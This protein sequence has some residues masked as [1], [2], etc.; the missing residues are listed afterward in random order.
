MKKLLLFA[1]LFPL[2]LFGQAWST[3]LDP[4]RAVDWSGAGFAIPNYTVPCATQPTMLA[5][6]SNA[7]ANTTSVVNS[8]NSCDT[9]HNVVNIPAGTYYLNMTQFPSHGFEVIRGAGAQSTT[10]IFQSTGGCVGGIGNQGFCMRDPGAIYNGNPA[11][12]PPSGSQQCSWTGGLTQGSTSIT[13][14]SCGGTPPNG[15]ILILDQADDTSDT[16][17]VYICQ[18][19]N[20]TNCNN[21]GT[22]NENGRVIS[23]TGHSQQQVTQITGVT[24]LGGGSYTV[25]ISPGVYFTNVRSGQSPG[26]WW[27]GF[28]QNEGVENMTLDGSA[29]T[30]GGTIGI[31]Q[32][33]QCWVSGII[34]LNAGRNHIGLYMSMSDVIQNSYFYGAQ[35]HGSSSYGNEFEETS[36]SL[37]QNNIYQQTVAPIMFGQGSGNVI[38]YNFD[39]YNEYTGNGSVPPDVLEASAASHNS[40]NE[41]NLWEGNIGQAIWQDNVWGSSAQN[42]FYRNAMSGWQKQFSGSAAVCGST[43]CESTAFILRPFNRALNFVGNVIGQ[44]SFNVAYE[45]YAT[46]T[47][48]GVNGSEDNSI[49]SLGWATGGFGGSS[50]GGCTATLC[51]SLVRS[52][53]MRWDNYD[54]VGKTVRQNTTEGCPASATYVTANCTNFGTPSTTLPASLYYASKPSWWPSTKAWPAVGPDVTTGNVSTC[55]GGTYASSRGTLSAQCTGGS[56][57]AASSTTAAWASHVVSNPAMDCYLKTLNGPPD[58]SGSVLAFNPVTCYAVTGNTYTATATNLVMHQGDPLPPLIFSMST[59]TGS[60]STVFN[61]QPTLSTT[62]TSSSTPGTYPITISAGTQSPVNPADSISYVGGTMTV[63]APDN[64]G[65]VLANSIAYPSGFF[66][67]PAFAAMN[68]TSNGVANMVGDGTTLNDRAFERL[69]FFSRWGADAKVNTVTSG[70]NCA[71]TWVSGTGFTGIA[72]AQPV[73]LAGVVRATVSV[74]SDTAMIVAGTCTTASNVDARLPW[75]TVSISGT[76]VTATAGPSFA[77]YT[78]NSITQMV[79]NGNTYTISTV[80]DSTHITLSTAPGNTSDADAYFGNLSSTSLNIGSRPL[81]LYFPSGTYLLSTQIIVPGS[82][83]NFFGTGPQSSILKLAPNSAQFQT[84]ATQFISPQSVNFNQNFREH[85]DSMGFEI[86]VGN[87]FAEALTWLGNNEGAVRNVQIWSDDSAALMGFNI[88]RSYSGPSMLEDIAIYG[89][90]TAFNTTQSEYSLPA[91][92]VTLEGQTVAG[93]DSIG[94]MKLQYR[95]LL[96]YEPPATYV[97]HPHASNSNVVL[98]DSEIIANG[99]PSVP[100]ILNS[101]SGSSIY[102]TNVSVSGYSTSLSDNG[103]GSVVTYTGNLTETWTGPAQTLFDSGSTPGALHLPIQETPQAG[104]NGSVASWVQLGSD[105]TTWQATINS[106]SNSTVYLPPGQYAS[107]AGALTINVPDAINHLQFFHAATPGGTPYTINL[108]VAGSSSTPLI[109]DGCL[110]NNC[111]LTQSGTRAVSARDGGYIHYTSSSTAN[112][113]IDDALMAQDGNPL[114]IPSGQHVWARQLNLEQTAGKHLV[115]NSCVF[116]ALGYKTEH[117]ADSMADVTTGQMELLGG[118]WYMLSAPVTNYTLFNVTNASFFTTGQA[119][120]NTNDGAPNQVIETRNGVTRNLPSPQTV[121]NQ[122]LPMYYA[123]GFSPPRTPSNFSG[124]VTALG[125]TKIQ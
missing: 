27:P 60:Y 47:T 104:D 89:F 83:W 37:V 92:K 73:R 24:S 45:M 49:F 61:G 78:A 18:Q 110:F 12:L 48:G 91:E 5:G 21:D 11:A 39:V 72:A 17:G 102:T 30:G 55:S 23:G 107:S 15:K 46:S 20:G 69:L 22:G 43:L 25:N 116:W 59:Y 88:T 57:A 124:S 6:S 79:I 74:S 119:F 44:P 115:C 1:L 16:S 9:T 53:L 7:T 38:A 121:N 28:V 98:T 62:A 3:I 80:T 33:Y 29:L 54:T 94:G 14:S 86:G 118:F 105:P 19:N 111:Y 63:I 93:L 82:D 70:G 123:F 95:R 114:T 101:T 99:T 96:A 50:N 87:A 8:M 122:Q 76:T 67:A 41:M 68:V 103:T 42:T 112:L 117:N 81:Y 4:S 100:A 125:S 109:I 40:G 90:Q 26:A 34:S 36:N 97:L 113:F 58:G 32:C 56:L 106:A 71:L 120:V 84:T 35:T 31:G 52:T 77:A 65:A 10:I 66:S 2:P 85:I 13:L 64:S 51:D 75:N 108:T